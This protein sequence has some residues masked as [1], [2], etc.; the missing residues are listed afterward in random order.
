[1][2]YQ[3][4]FFLWAYTKDHASAFLLLPSIPH[5]QDNHVGV[6]LF[7]IFGPNVIYSSRM[8]SFHRTKHDLNRNIYVRLTGYS[9]AVTQFKTVV[10]FQA[11]ICLQAINQS[12]CIS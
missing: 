11:V 10:P 1:M 3:D 4:L 8:C 12:P 9:S 7:Y 5:I 2:V 6:F